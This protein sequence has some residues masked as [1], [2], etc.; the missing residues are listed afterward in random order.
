MPKGLNSTWRCIR[1]GE[2]IVETAK[3]TTD[4]FAFTISGKCEVVNL[5]VPF[6]G[7]LNL[8]VSTEQKEFDQTTSLILHSVNRPGSQSFAVCPRDNQ[9]VTLY[10]NAFT[11]SLPIGTKYWFHVTTAG[12]IT[13]DVFIFEDTVLISRMNQGKNM[14][15]LTPMSRMYRQAFANQVGPI[16]KIKTED[17]FYYCNGHYVSPTGADCNEFLNVPPLESPL[18]MYPWPYQQLY[19][20]KSI[21]ATMGY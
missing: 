18:P 6:E 11:S 19:L 17:S 21:G 5:I 20:L 16:A 12:K 15:K 14:H 1:D 8:G 7:T 2:T 10:F 4:L 13:P 9:P 3:G